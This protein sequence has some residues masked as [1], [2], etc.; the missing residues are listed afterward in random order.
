MVKV[1]PTS[2]QQQQCVDISILLGLFNNTIKVEEIALSVLVEISFS[3]RD[4]AGGTVE[5]FN[6]TPH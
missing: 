5:S 6:V 3:F 2:N 4:T 1:T